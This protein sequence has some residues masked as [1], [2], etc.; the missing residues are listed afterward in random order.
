MISEFLKNENIG[1]VVL[2]V[3]S[4]RDLMQK[5]IYCYPATGDTLKM[6]KDV[7]DNKTTGKQQTKK[8]DHGPRVSA[9]IGDGS[10]GSSFH[11]PINASKI[12]SSLVAIH[13]KKS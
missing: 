6:V 9:D 1:W 3:P 8:K 10:I 2:Y 7:S 12:L 5:G 13:S 11:M 4:V